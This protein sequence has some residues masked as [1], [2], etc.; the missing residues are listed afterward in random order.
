MAVDR[1][2]G[3][4]GSGETVL[5]G[6]NTNRVVRVGETVRR[7]AGPWTPTVHLL[8]RQLEVAGFDAAPRV[9][10]MDERGR[11]VLSFIHGDTVGYPMPSFVWS[12]ATLMQVGQLLRRYHDLTATMTFPNAAWR[13]YAVVDGPAEVV[14]HCDWVPTTPYSGTAALSRWWT[15]TT[16]DRAVGWQTSRT[17]HTRGFP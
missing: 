11:E 5:H 9:L 8:L 12:D 13:P 6:G 14:C 2:G 15:G 10:G 16:P 17:P 7:T 3:T 1:P 4:S